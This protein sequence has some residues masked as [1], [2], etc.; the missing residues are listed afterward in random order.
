MRV[1][2]FG[3][4]FL[5]IFSLLCLYI[6]KRFINKLDLKPKYKKYLN[7][8][9]V[10]NLLGVLGYIVF[11]RYPIIPNEIY[12]LLSVPIGIIFLLF[13]TS[14]IYDILK[15]LIN[16]SSKDIKRREFF[17]KSLD[18]TALLAATSINAKAMYN[19]RHIQIEEVKIKIKNLKES[20]S[21]VQISDVHI[22][23]LVDKEFIASLV[24]KINL[25][26]ADVVVITGD[27]VDTNLKY[28]KAALEE[29]EN[30]KST[31]GTY[32]IVGNHEYF[33]GIENIIQA[34]KSL[35]I[36]VLENEN[37][38]IGKENSGFYLAGVYDRFGERYGEYK[39]DIKKA[40]ENTEA[41]PTILL[42]HQPKF[43]EEIPSTSNIDLILCGHT[44]GGQIMPFNL[45]VKLQQP[46]ISG[47]Y[48]HNET[49][50]VYVNKGTGFWGPPMRLGA[51]SEIT[52][53]NLI[54]N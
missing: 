34:M 28:A 7:Y 37:I 14:V 54:S 42:A 41:F 30:L 52:Y 6:S 18:I 20:Y 36:K 51:S 12:F 22:G 48:Q 5:I 1:L 25:L 23:G 50:Q 16:H 43:I 2:L 38:Y 46:Y 21:L 3:T 31:Y 44:H 47:L 19:A 40:L 11:R 53:I 17:K 24:K 39:P 33:H 9:L 49:T 32:F 10:L 35:N 27:L 8:F 45:L 4:I 13:S 29:L 26:K 15:Y